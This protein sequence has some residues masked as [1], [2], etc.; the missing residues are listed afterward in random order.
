MI[1]EVTRILLIVL[2]VAISLGIGFFL[3]RLTIRRLS[4]TFL[5]AWIVQTIGI[6][7]ALPAIALILIFAPVIYTSTFVSL[8]QIWSGLAL[9]YKSFDL[10]GLGTSIIISTLILA[11][12]IGIARTI[13][14]LSIRGWGD[15]RIDINIRTL[16]GRVCYIII[17]TF[18]FFWV[19][20]VWRVEL[21][22]PVAFIGTITIACAFAIQEILK[23]LVAGFYLLMERPFHIGDMITTATYTGRVED[24]AIR[25]TKLRLISGEQITIPNALMFGG[26]V[27]NDSFY[28]EKRVILELVMTQ[29]LFIKGETFSQV[30]RTIEQVETVMSKPEPLVTLSNYTGSN[31]TL[32]VQFWLT[33]SDVTTISDVMYELRQVLPHADIS[34]H[35]DAMIV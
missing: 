18:A 25:A 5:D 24:V 2:T 15:N 9:R 28:G 35:R 1:N 29:D 10:I 26:I 30:K 32:Y 13:M 27:L 21:T 17:I 31:L 11:I 14:T 33:S 7:V 3:R 6:I 16:I 34:I 12:A 8:D 19:L 20:A 23:N 22:V 4:Q